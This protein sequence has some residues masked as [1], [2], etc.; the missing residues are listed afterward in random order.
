MANSVDPDQTPHS[1][2]SNLGLHWLHRPTLTNSKV[3]FLIVS[4]VCIPDKKR[5]YNLT[6]TSLFFSLRHK[7]DVCVFK[8]T[9]NFKIGTVGWKIFL[10]C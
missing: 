2:M 5:L 7:K 3:L 4:F 8:V 10:F 9:W 6:N 1:A